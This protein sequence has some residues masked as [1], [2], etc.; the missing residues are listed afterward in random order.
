VSKRLSASTR[1]WIE[2]RNIFTDKDRSACAGKRL[3]YY[4]L[5][6]DF[7]RARKDWV[8]IMDCHDFLVRTGAV[9]SISWDSQRRQTRRII[10]MLASAQMAAIE[11]R[12]NKTTWIKAN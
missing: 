8:S 12:E 5:L 11:T 4:F 1:K 9:N 6:L 2:R 3:R 7:I 10:Y